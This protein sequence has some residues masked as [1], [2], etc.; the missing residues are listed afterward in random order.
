[1]SEERLNGVVELDSAGRDAADIGSQVFRMAISAS[2]RA[3]HFEIRLFL[4]MRSQS[5]NLRLPQALLDQL[6]ATQ[7][8]QSTSM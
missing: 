5:D 6:D 1:M 3:N 7:G 4:P 2:A 8:N